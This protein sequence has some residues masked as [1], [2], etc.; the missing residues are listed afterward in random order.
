MAN[1]GARGGDPF[2][3]GRLEEVVILKLIQDEQDE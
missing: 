1:K 2:P 3:S